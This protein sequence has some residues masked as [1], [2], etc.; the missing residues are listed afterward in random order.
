MRI[1][2][3]RAENFARLRAIEIRPEGL[4]DGQVAP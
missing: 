1:I 2:E 3:L 4:H